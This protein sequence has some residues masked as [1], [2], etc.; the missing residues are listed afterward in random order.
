MIGHDKNR[1]TNPYNP[2]M[3]I[4]TSVTRK[5]TT[6]NVIHPEQKIGREDAL[7]SYTIN[8]ATLVGAEKVKGSLETGKLA[9]FVIIDRDYMAIPEDEIRNIEPLAVYIDGKKAWSR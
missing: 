6:G 1:A 3:G 5:T 4:W 2:F 9:D 8:G 7:R